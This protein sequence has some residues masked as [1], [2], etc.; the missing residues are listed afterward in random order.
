M[1]EIS[2]LFLARQLRNTKNTRLKSIGGNDVITK[3]LRESF[4]VHS[5]VGNLQ[6]IVKLSFFPLTLFVFF[7]YD[8]KE[9][10]DQSKSGKDRQATIRITSDL[11]FLVR[12]TLSPDEGIYSLS[13][14]RY[15]EP[16]VLQAR[17][18][19]LSDYEVY[20]QVSTA[21]LNSRKRRVSKDQPGNLQTIQLEVSPS[22]TLR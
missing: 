3:K 8:F 14:C 6:T 19:F 20:Q 16:Q 4:C 18:G 9:R 21:A 15:T 11:N 22:S 13:S 1:W 5:I 10:S 2:F 7:M 12:P 17:E